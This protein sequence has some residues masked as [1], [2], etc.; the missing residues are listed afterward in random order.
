MKLSP[1]HTEKQ[2]RAAFDGQENWTT[3]IDIVEDRIL[4]RWLEPADRLLDGL[5]SGFAIVAL[6]C[7][8]LE[9]LWGFR[10]GNPVPH[11]GEQKVYRDILTGPSFGWTVTLADDFREFVRNGLMHDVVRRVDDG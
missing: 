8:V 7:I 3:A 10:N 6:D 4:G 5:H 9:S 2:W 1:H 11:G